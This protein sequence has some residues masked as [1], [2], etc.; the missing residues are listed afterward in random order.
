LIIFCFYSRNLDPW[1]PVNAVVAKVKKTGGQTISFAVGICYWLETS[2]S[3]PKGFGVG[4]AIPLYSR[5]K[6]PGTFL[7]FS[8]QNRA[9][10]I[11]QIG[12][13]I[14]FA[15]KSGRSGFHRLFDLI[16]DGIS[17]GNEDL[18]RW[19]DPQE[20]YQAFMSTHPGHAD[21]RYDQID[22]LVLVGIDFYGICHDLS[23][24]FS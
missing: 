4:F 19:I 6:W 5:V 8:I 12:Y 23:L 20:F 14:G 16:F 11:Q 13:L 10:F 22:F 21:V 15:G 17:V 3:G 7:P 9:D 1:H 2:D 18:G 24:I